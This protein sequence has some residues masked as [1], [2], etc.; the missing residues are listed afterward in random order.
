MTSWDQMREDRPLDALFPE[1]GEPAE[2][3]PIADARVFG[4]EQPVV[5]PRVL[6]VALEQGRAWAAALWQTPEDADALERE[7]RAVL[8]ATILHEL[9]QPPDRMDWA[10]RVFLGAHLFAYA[11]LDEA[12]RARL[13]AMG[14]VETPPDPEAYRERLKAWRAEAARGGWSLPRAPHSLWWLP[15]R[16]PEDPMSD[17]L[18][19]IEAQ[20]LL[21]LRGEVWGYT[22]G[23]PS[24]ALATLV[25]HH[26]NVVMRPGAEG[27]HH[28]DVLLVDREPGRPRWLSPMIFQGIADFVGV[29]LMAERH[30]QVQWAV[31]DADGH[32]LIQPPLL[33]VHTKKGPVDL[34]IGQELLDLL[35]M[36]Y[37]EHRAP[38]LLRDWLASRFA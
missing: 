29:V 17:K 15:L 32:G 26:F 9:S 18:R 19:D 24:R 2:A 21:R 35:V 34:S 38:P 20:L 12:Q 16:R 11:P 8:G 22:P 1:L 25:E 31:C 33:R 4:S 36:P 30:T 7:V 5:H 23:R 3:F 13:L 10:E 6:D 14:F 37:H 28:L 27:L